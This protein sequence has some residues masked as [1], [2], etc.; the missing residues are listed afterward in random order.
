[1]ERCLSQIT[2]ILEEGKATGAFPATLSTR[3]MLT[4]F[5]HLLSLDKSGKFFMQEELANEELMLQI[6][7]IFF[8]GITFKQ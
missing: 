6:G 8:E 4:I 1:M 2:A 3:L 5:I 7:C